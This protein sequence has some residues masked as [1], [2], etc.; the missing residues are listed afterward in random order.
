MPESQTCSEEGCNAPTDARGMCRS[1]YNRWHY[2]NGRGRYRKTEQ[3]PFGR[4]KPPAREEASQP[5]AWCEDL[6]QLRRAIGGG[7]VVAIGQR[8][9]VIDRIGEQLCFTSIEDALEWA[10]RPESRAG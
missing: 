8:G 10:T 4:T 6:T 7:A 1:H 5:V 2:S 9:V 3:T